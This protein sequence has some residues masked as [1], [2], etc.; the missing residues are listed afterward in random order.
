MKSIEDFYKEQR[1]KDQA[2]Q[3]ELERKK[4]VIYIYN[5]YSTP[6]I[7]IIKYISNY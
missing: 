6:Y 1:M 3:D 5:L 4:K 2:K 7:I